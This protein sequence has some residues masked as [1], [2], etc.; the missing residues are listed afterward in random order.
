MLRRD[1]LGVLPIVA[2]LRHRRTRRSLNP[3]RRARTVFVGRRPTAYSEA[4]TVLTRWIAHI[5]TAW[6]DTALAHFVLVDSRCC[7]VS[8]RPMTST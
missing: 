5:G 6:L 4:S 1:A 7:R 3:A 2:W 8:R